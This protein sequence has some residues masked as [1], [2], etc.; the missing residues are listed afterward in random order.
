MAMTVVE[1]GRKGGKV[2]SEEK[3]KAAEKNGV[4]G[5]RPPVKQ[6]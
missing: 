5:G 4:K 6:K 1:A 3:K 2:K